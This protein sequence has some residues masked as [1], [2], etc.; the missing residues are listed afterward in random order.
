MSV[1]DICSWRLSRAGVGL[2]LWQSPAEVHSQWPKCAWD[3]RTTDVEC[4]S[5]FCPRVN[6]TVS[7]TAIAWRAEEGDVCCTACTGIN[8]LS[9]KTG[10]CSMWV[11]RLSVL[12]CRPIHAGNRNLTTS[13]APL[14]RQE[15]GTILFMST[16]S[17][18][19]GC[20]SRGGNDNLPTVVYL[21]S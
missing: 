10:Q 17:N 11:C 5:L 16:V 3:G 18:Q 2:L 8:E 6:Q 14:K 15:Q 21:F 1:C 12:L 19:R 9:L 4:N 20:L 13:K 7:V